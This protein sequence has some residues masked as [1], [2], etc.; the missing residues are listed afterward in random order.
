MNS[1]NLPAAVGL[2]VL[3]RQSGP[4]QRPRRQP[5]VVAMPN[6]DRR[7]DNR[8]PTQGKAVLTVLDGSG[9]NGTHDILTRDV[10]FSGV[11]FLLREALSV[12]QSCRI[13]VQGPGA[14]THLCEVIRSRQLS[15]GRFEMAVEFRKTL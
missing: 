3:P 1:S 6:I 5:S 13:K 11:S 4:H 12:G 2:G 15:N 7:R 14:A 10:S 9:A 8:A